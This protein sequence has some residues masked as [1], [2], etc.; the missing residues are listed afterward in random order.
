MK[1][2]LLFTSLLVVIFTACK[3]DNNDTT[4]IFQ[5]HRD[6]IVNLSDKITAIKTDLFFS[7]SELKIVDDYL[8]VNDW[9]SMDTKGIHLY[10]KKSFAFVASTAFR[11][12][13]PGEISSQGRI[14]V[15]PNNKIFWVP[16]HGKRVT[17]KFYLDSALNNE[18]YLPTEKKEL[19][20]ELFLDRYDFLNDSI[21]LGKAVH[22][23][24]FNAFDMAMAKMNLKTNTT[25]RFG[26]E[27]PESVGKKSNSYFLLSRE[28]KFYVNAF[29][30][31]DLI[32]ICD[33]DGNLKCN[34][35]GPGY[36]YN[37]DKHNSYFHGVDILNNKII[38]SYNGDANMIFDEKGN[39][40]HG[41]SPSKI[42][43]F[44]FEG[45]YLQTYETG[46]K[47]SYFCIDKENNRIIAYFQ[48]RENP[49]GYINLEL[50]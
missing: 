25:E 17:F 34:I 50:D 5:K 3:N 48:D 1:N 7:D 45:N 27:H 6:N 37:K 38:V 8:L 42:M 40:L 2:I 43:V 46:S 28:N 20:D 10:D 19:F 11:G 44:D 22:V 13:G 4:E 24:N 16:D 35:Y 12:R 29:V 33:L 30:F 21:A 36:I 47:F 26:Y 18:L 39:P 41:N 49:L 23:V 14:T 32:T 9:H 15:E 31:L